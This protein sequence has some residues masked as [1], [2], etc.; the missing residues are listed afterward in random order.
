[1]I[2]NFGPLTLPDGA[3]PSV[4]GVRPEHFASGG[5]V[6]V[7]AGGRSGIKVGDRLKV[8]F[9]AEEAHYFDAA[10]QRLPFFDRASAS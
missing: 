6:L 1:V 4:V 5:N 7:Q 2:E 8:G 10:G 9:A 3:S